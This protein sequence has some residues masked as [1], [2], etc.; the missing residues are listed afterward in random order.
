MSWFTHRWKRDVGGIDF[1]Q[2]VIGLTIVAIAAVGTFQALNYGNEQLNY[3]MRYRKAMSIARSHLEYWQG[4][5]HIDFNAGDQRTKAGN[6]GQPVEATLLDEGDPNTADDDVNCY[7]RY[8]PLEPV[9]L[10]L[11]GAGLDHW[12]I[13][14]KVTW[15]EP[16]QDLIRDVPNEVK[17]QGTM[18]AAA[19]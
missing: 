19:L 4:R 15:W 14:V 16:D 10:P 8:G 9:D 7:V 2:I 12:T 13:K 1:I 6:F 11:T 17:L 3:Q 5:I 18:V